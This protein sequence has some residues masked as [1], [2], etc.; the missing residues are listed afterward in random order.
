MSK[1]KHSCDLPFHHIATRPDGR[2][3]PCCYFRWEETPA[4]LTVN[5]KDPFNHPFL[6]DLRNKMLKDEYIEGCS[7]CYKD[8]ETSGRSMRQDMNTVTHYGFP[9][10]GRGKVP[11]LT[12]IDLTFSNVCN[13]KCR[14]CG[15]E[16]STSWYS[17]AKKLGIKHSGII[18]KNT[19]LDE[20]NLSELRFIKLLGGEPLMEEAKL[21]DLLKKCNRKELTLLLVTNATIRP[22]GELYD[23]L[24]EVKNVKVELSVDSYGKLNDFLR[25][26]SEWD[27]VVDN[28]FWFIEQ[29]V[30]PSV[31]SVASIYNIN[32]VH[33]LISFCKNLEL[34]HQYVMVDGPDWM[35]PR[36]LPNKVKTELINSYNNKEEPI[37]KLIVDE[38]KQEGN[39]SLFVDMD[40]K[41]NELRKEH[42]APYNEWLFERIHNEIG[43]VLSSR[44][45]SIST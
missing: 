44:I 21:I 11:K 43:D 36:N 20:Y 15:P 13:N 28:I 4:D 33:E 25:K 30:N 12:N 31:H 27:E 7:K 26:G 19:I 10:E 17:D 24:K 40:T 38:L 22:K 9:E 45:P 39:F 29:G 14:M 42:W 34:D 6:K 5:H 8:E 1:R 2:V 3:F 16:L 41:L 23:L 32:L 37:Y 35:R 18:A